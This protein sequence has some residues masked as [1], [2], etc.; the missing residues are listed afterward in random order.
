MKEY[1]LN[2]KVDD[3]ETINNIMHDLSYYNC[4]IHMDKKDP[5]KIYTFE[6]NHNSYNRLG[7]RKGRT[8]EEF[9]NDMNYFNYVSKILEAFGISYTQK[10]FRY[11]VEC[12]RLMNTFGLENYTMEKD[13]YPIVSK[14][15]GTNVSS[16]EHNI[17]NAISCAWDKNKDVTDSEKSQMRFFEKRPS[18]VKFL[19]HI[20]RLTFLA[21][22]G[23]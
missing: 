19:K 14:W 8:T 12:V 6:F 15:Y 3:V 23:A 20:C 17:R 21:Y 5:S 16:I 7:E 22:M 11:I 10:G 13:V 1:Y 9:K 4:D 2:I 18:N